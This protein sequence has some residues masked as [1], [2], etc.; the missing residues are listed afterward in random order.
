MAMYW[1]N[2][3]DIIESTLNPNLNVDVFAAVGLREWCITY[4]KMMKS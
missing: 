2:W 3:D 1:R 4:F